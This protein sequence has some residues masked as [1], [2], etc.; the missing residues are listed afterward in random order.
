MDRK[1]H[2]EKV[3]GSRQ[4]ADV[5]WYQRDATVSLDLIRKAVAPPARI[6]DV[7][8][9]ASTLV[10]GLLKA[11]Y[12]RPTVL[13][14]SASGLRHA[15]HRLGVRAGEVTW[16]EADVLATEFPEGA[17]DIWHDR[18]LLHFLTDAAERARY[19]TQVRRAL[20]PGGLLV[21]A[22]F[23]DDGPAR[24]SGL[25]VARYSPPQL[26][27]VF[28]DDFVVRSSCREEHRTPG[29]SVQPF[30]WGVWRYP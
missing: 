6:I 7:G 19:V 16:L 12:G 26:H 22:T 30:T 17:Y 8:G 3:Y 20:R 24:C 9:G 29:G 21:V 23:A 28:G 14:I 15:Q 25:D 11:G 2:W 10:D 5:S 18:A 1:T 27:D 4:P 13:D